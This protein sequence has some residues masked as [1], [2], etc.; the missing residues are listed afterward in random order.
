M[1]FIKRKL[2]EN[3]SLG[4]FLAIGITVGLT[5]V[6]IP[7]DMALTVAGCVAGVAPDLNISAKE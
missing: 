2:R 6:G 1:E 7:M 5:Y 3:S 4:A